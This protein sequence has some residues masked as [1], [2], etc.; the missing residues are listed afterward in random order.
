[1]TRL[2]PMTDLSAPLPVRQVGALNGGRRVDYVLQERPFESLNE[3]VFA[4]QSHLCYW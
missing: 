2:S 1:M 4:F 3:Y